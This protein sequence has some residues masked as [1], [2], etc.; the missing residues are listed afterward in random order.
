V[1]ETRTATSDSPAHGYLQADEPIT[2]RSED[3]LGR[4]RF[5]EAIANQVL[6]SP[7]RQAFVIALDGAW[8]SGKTSVLN[9]IEEVVVEQSDTVVLRFNPWLFSGTEELVLRFL[10]ELGTQLRE[11]GEVKEKRDERSSSDAYTF[12]LTGV[13]ASVL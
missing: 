1:N 5:A 8:G 12:P 10:Y 4:A 2:R 11:L 6:Q 7:P 9:M 13:D 3:Q